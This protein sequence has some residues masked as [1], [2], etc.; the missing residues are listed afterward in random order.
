MDD[1]VKA[2]LWRQ[3]GAAIDTIGNAM[4]ACPDEAWAVGPPERQVWYL[5]YHTL[6]WLD[7]YL[8]NEGNAYVPPAP[9]GMEEMDPAGAFPPQPHTRDELHALLRHG[10]A[11]CK[12][13]IMGLTAETAW[14][15][16]RLGSKA[17]GPLLELLLYNLRHVQHHAAQMNLLL[18]QLTDSATGWVYV[19]R[20]D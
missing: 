12:A 1:A 3:F 16:R 4:D 8:A 18:R 19:A 14:E 13:T 2:V 7:F 15:T 10:R 9:F 6:F 20:E 11:R 5:A 17:E